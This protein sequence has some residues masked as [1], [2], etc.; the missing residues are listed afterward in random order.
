[1]SSVGERCAEMQQWAK[2]ELT[3]EER[4]KANKGLAK[5]AGMFLATVVF[6]RFF[7]ELMAIKLGTLAG[8]VALSIL[9]DRRYEESLKSQVDRVIA[10]DTARRERLAARA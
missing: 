6:S 2:D 4:W 9:E 3:N 1:M 8:V 10:V 7:G 5:A